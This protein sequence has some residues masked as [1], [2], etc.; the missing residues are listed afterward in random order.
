MWGGS[1]IQLDP[2]SDFGWW[3]TFAL[4][5]FKNFWGGIR[6]GPKPCE[7]RTDNKS[8]NIYGVTMTNR[9]KDVIPYVS[10]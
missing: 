5:H 2:I 9:R 3:A 1:Q 4:P 10:F 7:G 6:Y 8:F